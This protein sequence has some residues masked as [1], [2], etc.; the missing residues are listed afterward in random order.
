MLLVSVLKDE[1]NLIK[2]YKR[3]KSYSIF[4]VMNQPNISLLENLFSYQTDPTSSVSELSDPD[5]Y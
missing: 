3:E 4:F 1:Q 2:I 5:I